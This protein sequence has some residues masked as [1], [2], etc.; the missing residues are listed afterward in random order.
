MIQSNGE[1][2]YQ[3]RYQ[4][5]PTAASQAPGRVEILGNHTDYN[6]G[7]VLTV[8]ID[9]TI[10]LHGEACSEPFAAI[11]SA[12]LDDETRFPLDQIERDPQHMWA[13]YVKG[14]LLQLRKRGISFG[15]FRA[16][17][18]GD[19]PIG[20]GVSSSAA[21][22]AASALFV[23]ALYPYDMDVMN[24]AKLC[25]AAENEFVGMPCGLLDQFSSF[26]GKQDSFLCLDCQTLEHKSLTLTVEAPR[27]V[28]CDSGVKHELVESEYKDRRGQCEGAARTLG[29]HLGREVSMLRDISILEFMD[30]EDVL[31][32]V[33]R[34]RARH[35]F[36][37][38][39]R[40]QR[41]VAALQLNDL[42]H[43][44]ELVHQSH[45]SSRDLFENSCPELD[46]LVE[47]AVQIEGCYGAKLT[48]GGFGGWT[49]NLVESDQVDPFVAKIT[50]YFEQ[51]Y[52]RACK[53]MV[54]AIG[55][56][57]RIL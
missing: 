44:G 24:M 42:K 6:G 9:K 3:E 35:V 52:G 32:D 25:R 33:Q 7:F 11:Y 34:I 53:T 30:L 54:C 22:E 39:Q 47:Q 5:N 20:G 16:V 43:L 28:L 10:S 1:K 48:G 55:D 21:L 41:G 2:L 14:V 18:S 13:N 27:L 50:E 23:K 45:E 8:A 29:E 31:D 46:F 37:E 51:K 26:F 38:N 57:A 56:G 40:V 17:I 19:L 36:Y 49:V 12:A 4:N 15:G